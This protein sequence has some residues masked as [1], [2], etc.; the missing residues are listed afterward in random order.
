[1]FETT[2]EDWRQPIGAAITIGS[3]GRLGAAVY[4][5]QVFQKRA[6]VLL[7]TIDALSARVAALEAQKPPKPL[8]YRDSK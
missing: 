4:D 5:L 1:M 8:I 6:D 3:I 7:T 2:D